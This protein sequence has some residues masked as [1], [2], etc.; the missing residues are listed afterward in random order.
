MSPN[1]YFFPPAWVAQARNTIYVSRDQNERRRLRRRG[2]VKNTRAATLERI[3]DAAGLSSD[4]R[5]AAWLRAA[6][7]K[8]AEGQILINGP[9]DA[10]IVCLG[11]IDSRH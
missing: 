1:T 6:L 2:Y 8:C 11:S 5:A 4:A 3:A 9:A 10:D 7:A